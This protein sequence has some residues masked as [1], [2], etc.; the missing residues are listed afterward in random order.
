KAAP[1]YLGTP[2]CF[3][4][5]V[6]EPPGA[7]PPAAPRVSGPEVPRVLC[8]SSRSCRRWPMR[9]RGV[10]GGT[11]IGAPPLYG[12]EREACLWCGGVLMACSGVLCLL[13][14][15][16]PGGGG[17]GR[18]FLSGA[19]GGAAPAGE[20]AAASHAPPAPPALPTA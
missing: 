20:R 16:G 4:V 19:R 12:C 11:P 8:W 18:W 6:S 2:D 15:A 14:E 13:P 9:Q 17:G 5:I 10:D 7:A 3:V 1:V